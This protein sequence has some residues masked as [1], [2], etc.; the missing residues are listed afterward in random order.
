ML[1]VGGTTTPSIPTNQGNN[2]PYEGWFVVQVVPRLEQRVAMMLECKGYEHY[3]PLIR[4]NACNRPDERKP[5]FPGYLFCRLQPDSKGL[6]VGTPGV[7]RLLGHRCGV[8]TLNPDEVQNIH[9]IVGSDITAE[10]G[11]IVRLGSKVVIEN[12]P[13]RGLRGILTQFKGRERIAV[14]VELL[15]RSILVALN[16]WEVRYCE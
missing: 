7:I 3:L 1:H 15:C 2:H 16:A 8:S 14:S 11:E 10:A 4:G 9:R 13:L 5:L 12:G 6:V